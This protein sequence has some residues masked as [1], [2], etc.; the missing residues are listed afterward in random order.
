MKKP[1]IPKNF[2]LKCYNNVAKRR[3]KYDNDKRKLGT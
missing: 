3:D 1:G 2:T